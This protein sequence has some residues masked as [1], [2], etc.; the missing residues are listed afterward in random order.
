[1]A[2][3]RVSNRSPRCS[4]SGARDPSGDID[5]T[6]PCRTRPSGSGDGEES[7]AGRVG[8]GARELVCMEMDPAM[9]APRLFGRVGLR[10]VRRVVG[11]RGL[12]RG[13][14]DQFAARHGDSSDG[15]FEH[16]ECTLGNSPSLP[17]GGNLTG[18]QIFLSLERFRRS[19]SGAMAA[20]GARKGKGRGM[21]GERRGC[22]QIAEPEGDTGA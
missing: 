6:R 22:G 21:E 19:S 11:S 12:R 4:P 9:S 17:S 10:L 7:E 18:R 15:R 3:R 16:V 2:S 1:M 13:L 8:V 14:S 20:A 5:D